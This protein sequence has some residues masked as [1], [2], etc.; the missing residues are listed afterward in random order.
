[1]PAWTYAAEGQSL[2]LMRR[3][4]EVEA[5][6]PMLPAPEAWI[7]ADP[8]GAGGLALFLISG[9]R[10]EDGSA[11]SGETRPRVSMRAKWAEDGSDGRNDRG[12]GGRAEGEGE[13]RAVASEGE[14]AALPP[15]PS[16]GTPGKG[17]WTKKNRE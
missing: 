17:K 8:T 14:E 12:S 9:R 6:L 2:A 13:R 11:A 16:R 5:R 1:M 15:A 7:P 10:G 3:C 4:R